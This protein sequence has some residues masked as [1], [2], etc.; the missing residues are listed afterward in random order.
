MITIV[1][2]LKTEQNLLNQLIRESMNWMMLSMIGIY[3]PESKDRSQNND[4]TFVKS[5][6]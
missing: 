1:A 6:Y 5:H 2:H 4:K 3:G